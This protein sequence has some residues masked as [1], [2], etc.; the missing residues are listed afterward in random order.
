MQQFTGWQYLLIDVANAYGHD[1]LTFDE[2]IKWAEE[3]LTQLEGLTD[4][5]D[6][7]PLYV[8]ATMA[9]RKAQQGIPSGHLVGFDGV[10]S[11]VQIMSAITGCEAGAMST[12]LIDTGERPDA[13]SKT[14]KVMNELLQ[15][16][17]LSVDVPRKKA[18][19]ALMTSFYGSKAKPKEI[20]GEETPELAAFYKAAEIVAPGAWELLQVL[21]ASWQPY[22][23]EH[24]WQ[25]PDGYQAKVK[26]MQSVE[27]RI[28]I[29]ELDHTS[30]N[31]TWNENVGD[32]RGL[33]NIANVIHSIDAYVLR[34][35]HRRCNYDAALVEQA[36]LA[37]M[38]EADQRKCREAAQ[39]PL[40]DYASDEIQYYMGLYERT[41]MADVVIL[42]HLLGG[43]VS[44]LSD[45]HIEDLSRITGKMLEHV[46]F[47]VVTI[48]DEFKCHPNNMNQLRYWYKEILAE[49]A[50]SVILA[51]ILGQLHGMGGTYDKLS[52]NLGDKIRECNYALC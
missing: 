25:L 21:R 37:L 2:R 41:G 8:K 18:K 23:L 40:N 12:G 28:E 39:C 49:L 19:E 26:V 46:P 34:S 4:K 6:S 16:D 44:Y 9:I 15:A 32:K 51:D 20:F 22:A 52:P 7:K 3:N 42:P 38:A 17:G 45:E 31:Y 50:D 43:Q 1:K 47:H 5:A 10:C 29:D 27:A 24:S 30:F 14:T 33:S 11:G 36:D 48:H 35:V 13:Y